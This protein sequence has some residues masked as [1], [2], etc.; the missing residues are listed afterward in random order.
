M[1]PPTI[2]AKWI[3]CPT[4]SIRTMLAANS[5]TMYPRRA[6]RNAISMPK[7]KPKSL[8]LHL[9]NAV[10]PFNRQTSFVQLPGEF[11]PQLEFVP[12]RDYSA[13]HDFAS[14]TSRPLFRKSALRSFV[15]HRHERRVALRVNVPKPILSAFKP[16][17][18]AR[19]V[20]GVRS[21]HPIAASCSAACRQNVSHTK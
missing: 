8:S 19:V 12:N 7:C 2:T 10:W 14:T 20:I 21:H 4:H 3:G 17:V 18:A 11:T 6:C 15:P 16:T 5:K 1:P 9:L 13:P